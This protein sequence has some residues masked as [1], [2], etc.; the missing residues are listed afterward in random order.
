MSNESFDNRG[1]MTHRGNTWRIDNALVE[2]VS[3]SGVRSGHLLISY[4]VRGQH[5]LLF[6]EVIRLN[7]ERTTT[8]TMLNRPISL[9]GI[10]PGMR[11]DATVSPAM[12]SSIPPQTSAFHIAVRQGA[13]R[14]P[15]PPRPPAPASRMITDRIV[16]VDIRGRM[17]IT[18]HP[19]QLHQQMKFVVTNE[20]V[21][22]NRNGNRIS[23]GMLR[24]RQTVR[25]T[26]A[27][28]QTMSIPPQTTAYRVQLL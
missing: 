9:G 11:V 14:P 27:D 6:M 17:F 4:A 22:L 16:E 7:V 12:T 24:P 1:T 10:R 28:F 15:A 25:V 18:G 5:N 26:H 13:Q 23:L 2:E 20:T 21:I 3:V 19:N 8:I